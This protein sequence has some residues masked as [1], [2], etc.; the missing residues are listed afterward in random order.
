MVDEETVTIGSDVFEFDTHD[1]ESLANSGAIR[2]NV[3]GGSTVKSQGTLTLDTQPI[4]GDTMTLG[5]KVYTFVPDGTANAD[6]EI[7]VGSD[8][9]GAKVNVVAAINGSDGYNTAHTLVSAA[10]FAVND[11]VI[12]ALAGGV[13][14]DSI[15]STETFDAA[16]NIFDAATLGTT[17]AGV[18]PPAG[19]ASDALLAAINASGTEDVVAKDIDANEVLLMMD[20]VGADTTA[21]AEDMAGSNNTV[22]TA[23]AHGAAPAS[24]ATARQARVPTAQEVATGNLHVALDFIPTLVIVQVRTTS[25][26]ALVAWNGIAKITSGDNPYITL[27]NSG[28]VDWSV[29][30]TVY[31]IAFA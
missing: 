20:A 7:D 13:P 1:S 14:G 26:G 8:L 23:F 21:L 27:D 29:N 17:T 30:E 31:V 5:S 19:E 15:A 11:C 18:S 10:A 25:T 2:V 6:G 28:N 3:S 4:S 12:T 16:G 24:V 9:A 22:D